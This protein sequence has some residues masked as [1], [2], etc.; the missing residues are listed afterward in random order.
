MTHNILASSTV[1]QLS[2][3]QLDISVAKHKVGAMNLQYDN[4]L[5]GCMKS[6]LIN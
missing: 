4:G 2:A 6:E 1:H 3:G 5:H